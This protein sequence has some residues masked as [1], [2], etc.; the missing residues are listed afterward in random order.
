MV[1]KMAFCTYIHQSPFMKLATALAFC[2]L[3]LV[4]VRESAM[5]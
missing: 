5:N 3:M 2:I 1:K 4:V